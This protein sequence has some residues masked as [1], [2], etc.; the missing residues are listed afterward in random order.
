MDIEGGRSDYALGQLDES[1]LEDDPIAELR[2][3]VQLAVASN[4]TEP[5]AM[6]L[7][8]VGE[9]GRPSVRM[10]LLRAIDERGLSFFTNYESRK[11]SEL[12]TNPF[13]ALSM[14]WGSLER[15]IRVEGS[16]ERLSA[17]E[18]TNYFLTRPRA[19]QLAAHASPQSQVIPNR[20]VLESLVQ[21][22]A[23]QFQDEVPKPD[24]WGGYRIVPD[25]FEFWQG[26]RSRLHDRIR[27][28]RI[29]ASWQTERLAP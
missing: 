8:T 25:V 17:E 4:V 20:Q 19:S 21:N 10:V 7:A 24:N 29:G 22:A 28:R 16:V 27:Y 23:D 3:W 9:D 5:A 15:Q 14:W 2:K 26:R 18:S 1:T 13:A 11:A 12:D 6:A